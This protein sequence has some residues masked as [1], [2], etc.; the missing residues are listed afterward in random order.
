MSITG[1]TGSTSQTAT[2]HRAAN[3]TLGKNDFLKIL[4]AQL[5]NQDPSNPME[6]TQFIAQMA[7]FSSLEQMQNVN[8]TSSLQQAMMSIG[9]D[10]KAKVVDGKGG[11]ELVFGRITAVQQT[12]DNIYL[13]LDN[14][15]QIKDS[16]V[17]SLMNSEGMLQEAQN[18][19][20]K[21]VYLKNPNGFGRGSELA[22]TGENTVTDEKGRTI[23]QLQTSDGKTIGL[24]DI[25][26]VAT[27]MGT[28]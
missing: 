2:T 5:Q 9:S 23:I 4:V 22:I 17:D 28:L 25:W 21:N 12:G 3:G 16:D 7:Q 1:V 6:D 10:V 18:M 13:T 19:V 24:K 15:R 14:G 20:G 8:K 26:N 27:D 11:Q